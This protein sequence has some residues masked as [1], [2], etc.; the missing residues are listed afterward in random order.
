MLFSR[1]R[2]YL[3]LVTVL[4]LT[5]LPCMAFNFLA[6]MSFRIVTEKPVEDI[7]V[8]CVKSKDYLVAH[9]ASS[10]A[11]IYNEMVVN[12]NQDFSCGPTIS[13]KPSRL[14]VYHPTYVF[15][16]EKAGDK[17]DHIISMVPATEKLQQLERKYLDG[18]WRKSS[19][20]LNQFITYVDSV[21]PFYGHK[22]RDYLKYYN[23]DVQPD[24]KVLKKKY[25][26]GVK[27][28][29]LSQ[30][31]LR[32]KYDRSPA[33][34]FVSKSLVPCDS[35]ERGRCKEEGMEYRPE[36]MINKMLDYAWGEK[37]WAPYFRNEADKNRAF[38]SKQTFLAV[39]NDPDVKGGTWFLIDAWS[40]AEIKKKYPGLV[41]YEDKP[42]W[43]S[44][45]Q[46]QRFT[47]CNGEKLHWDIDKPAGW[48]FWI[49]KTG[50]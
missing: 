38:G 20:P 16:E 47:T 24:Y 9:N 5:P 14:E 8:R 3:A 19:V 36:V 18:Y 31:E 25:D 15:H 23:E 4:L 50:L 28:C 40:K 46:K 2:K 13:G 37:L 43:M 33:R 21:C 42:G 29:L 39:Y 10:Y 17:V 1:R 45:S 35:L 7:V 49:T 22:A 44:E 11:V 34:T 30:E 26:A 48:G 6:G 41:V 27:A 12:S 32:H